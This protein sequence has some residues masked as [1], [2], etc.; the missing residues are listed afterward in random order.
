MPVKQSYIYIIQI[1]TPADGNSVRRQQKIENV[2]QGRAACA[3]LIKITQSTVFKATND[4]SIAAECVRII[5][6]LN[7]AP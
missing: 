2:N 6:S 3:S 7:L 1:I 5:A 4:P